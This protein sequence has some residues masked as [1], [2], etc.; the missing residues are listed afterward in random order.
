MPGLVTALAL[1]YFVERYAGG[2]LYQSATLLVLAYSILFFPL[3]LVAVRASVAAR[4]GPARGRRAV[5]RPWSGRRS[6]SG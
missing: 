5:A 6:C 1:S 4:P 2:F 3:A